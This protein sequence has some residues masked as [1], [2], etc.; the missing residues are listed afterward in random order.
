V[1]LLG[2]FGAR[3]IVAPCLPRYSPGLAYGLASPKSGPGGSGKITST[4]AGLY[5][6]AAPTAAL[7]AK[8]KIVETKKTLALENLCM[9]DFE[10]LGTKIIV[11]SLFGNKYC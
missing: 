9:S 2:L 6:F 7:F 3:G 4:R 10:N 8:L 5:S 11:L 1:T